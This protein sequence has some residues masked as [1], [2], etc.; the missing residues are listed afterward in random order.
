MQVLENLEPEEI[1]NSDQMDAALADPKMLGMQFLNG[2]NKRYWVDIDVTLAFLVHWEK[3]GEA[4]PFDGIQSAC[5]THHHFAFSPY[6]TS[7]M[8]VRWWEHEYVIPIDED[9]IANDE[10]WGRR[11]L[12]PK[13]ALAR[14]GFHLNT[15]TCNL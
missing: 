13:A 1:L 8:H 2:A 6:P 10:Y 7:K 3:D 9:G 11:L 14:Q 4:L 12:G 15:E 5:K